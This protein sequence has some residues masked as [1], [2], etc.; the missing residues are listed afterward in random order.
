MVSSSSRAAA[1]PTRC[2]A[3]CGLSETVGTTTAR[4]DAAERQALFFHV[5]QRSIGDLIL[6]STRPSWWP[7]LIS[8]LTVA[9]EM[10]S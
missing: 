8:R 5:D 2:R 10:P 6:I 7:R 3:V 4:S 9:C 1:S